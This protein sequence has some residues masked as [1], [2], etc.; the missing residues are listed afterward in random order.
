LS[1]ARPVDWEQVEVPVWDARALLGA[2]EVAV[3]SD[4]ETAA[5]S[6]EQELPP[7]GAETL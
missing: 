2:Q 6:A 3:T 4:L 1:L 5:G 7:A